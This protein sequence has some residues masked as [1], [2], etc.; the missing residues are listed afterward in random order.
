VLFNPIDVYLNGD[1]IRVINL[2]P[3]G[4]HPDFHGQGIG[5]RLVTEGHQV[6]AAKGYDCS[7]LL[8][9]P[10][11]YPRFGYRTKS[12][13]ASSVTVASQSLAAI[14]LE[15][16]APVPDDIVVLA[17]LHH[18]NECNVN[19]SFVP[20]MSF[21]EWL[22]PNP[23]FACTV[24]RH[25]GEIVGYTRGTREDLRLF[26]ARDAEMARG[27]AKHLAGDAAEITLP[28]HPNSLCANAF[29]AQPTVNAWDAAMICPLHADSRIWGYLN[30][31]ENGG[32]IGRIV[33]S[34]VFDVA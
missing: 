21:V 23:M 17:K 9:H 27:I 13:G 31:I 12:Y 3:L 4:V 25:T 14:P 26:L 18:M 11:Y 22:S 30:D 29:D 6:I 16:A 1:I 5:S 24:Y 10:P 28:L 33:W 2:S 32:L 15:T 7:I 8:G 34:S 19:L 20:E